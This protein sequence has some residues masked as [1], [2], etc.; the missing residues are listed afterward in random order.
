MSSELSQLLNEDDPLAPTAEH[1]RQGWVWLA[2]VLTGITICVPVFFMGAQLAGKQQFFAF[3]LACILGGGLAGSVAVAT[4]LIGQRTGLPTAVLARCAFG[5]GGYV[6]AN[7]AMVLGAIGWFGIQTAVFSEAF[8]KLALQVWG[9]TLPR[10]PVIIAAGLL[11]SSTA[12]VGFR[13]LGKLSYIAIPLLLV[14]LLLPLWFYLSDG[15]IGAIMSRQLE[16]TPIPFGTIMAMVAGAY[17]GATTMPDLTRFMRSGPHTLTGVLINFGVVYPGLLILT[18][19]LAIAAKEGDFLQ[20]MLNLNFGTP[21][22]IVLLL[23][24]WTTNDTNVY[25]AAISANL[26]LPAWKRWQLTVGAGLLGTLSAIFGIFEYFTD[27]LI[28]SGNLFAPMAGVYVFDYFLDKDRY[29][30]HALN[31][32]DLATDPRCFIP[33]FRGRQLLAWM[34]G[35]GVGISTAPKGNMGFELFSIT[36]VPMLDALLSA[37]C[38]LVVMNFRRSRS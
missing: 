5:T 27:W 30:K 23:S 36:T 6:V 16:V 3:A 12:V 26:F 31:A 7:V 4:G 33:R 14:L 13:G 8:L 22:I 37:G 25:S 24:T 19:A 38:A 34:L 9:L 11:M 32:Q 10:L 15:G 29:H 21:A 18:G 1:S 28:F 2:S 20:I 17:S 35:L